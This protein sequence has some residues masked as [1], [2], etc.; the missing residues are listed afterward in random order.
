[1]EA[2]GE[3]SLPDE[4]GSQSLCP[5]SQSAA[6]AAPSWAHLH[7][8]IIVMVMGSLMSAAGGLLFLLRSSGVT[9]A[10]SSVA[11]ACLSIGLMFVVVGLVWIPILKEKQR[12]KR[13][14]QGE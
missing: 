9:E 3:T 6:A 14:S 7:K 11:S 5:D 10:S 13:F 12:R 4:S 2:I 1:M 8:P